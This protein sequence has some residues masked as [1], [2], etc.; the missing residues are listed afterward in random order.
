M[1]TEQTP[2]TGKENPRDLPPQLQTLAE[3]YAAFNQRDLEKMA[4][5]WAPSD[6]AVIINPVGITRGWQEIRA[7]YA[8]MFSGPGSGQVE[9]YDYSVQVDGE[10]CYSVG[11]E[12]GE[13]RQ[14]GTS[15]PL[16]ARTTNI[17]KLIGGRWRLV[18]HHV[19]MDDPE[20]LA[21]FQRASSAQRTK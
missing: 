10:L 16:A 6:E 20:M 19:S 4:Q 8:R 1:K 5:V 7:G 2:I 3:F 15:I 11:R 14:P 17:L 18:H 21:A 13:F 12:R 9:F